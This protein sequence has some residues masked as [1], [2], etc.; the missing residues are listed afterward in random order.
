MLSYPIGDLYIYSPLNPEQKGHHKEE[1][2]TAGFRMV[3]A[4][5]GKI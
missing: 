1:I 4:I 2:K 3:G 5:D